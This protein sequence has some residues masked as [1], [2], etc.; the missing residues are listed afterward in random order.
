MR[1]EYDS[2][3]N[4]LSIDLI[5]VERWDHGEQVD[6][7]YCNVA[8]ADGRVANVELLDPADHLQLLDVA[9]RRYDL[10]A[11]ELQAAARSAIAAP[12]RVVELAVG[13]RLTA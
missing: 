4:A 12:D 8:F 9:A 3:A 10:D 11:E 13:A 5:A 1:A 7:D 6:D 2:L